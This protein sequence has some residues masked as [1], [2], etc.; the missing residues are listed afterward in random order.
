M[1]KYVLCVVCGQTNKNGEK[2]GGI[3]YKLHICRSFYDI[4]RKRSQ[5]GKIRVVMFTTHEK[6]ILI[7][8]LILIITYLF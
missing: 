3:N 5:N 4:L 2:F 7:I 6:I 1:I 8:I